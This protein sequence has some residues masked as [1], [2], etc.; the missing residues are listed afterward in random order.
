[1]TEVKIKTTDTTIDIAADNHAG[2]KVICAVC[3]ATVCNLINILEKEQDDRHLE[4][5]RW[6]VSSGHSRIEAKTLPEFI[7]RFEAIVDTVVIAFKSLA[8][9][10][11]EHI[12][13]SIR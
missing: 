4:Y 9:H 7:T 5:L 13:V 6:D 10:Y 1:M 2:Q 3:S 12:K 11:P 8:E